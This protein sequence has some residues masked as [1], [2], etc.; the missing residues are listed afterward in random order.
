MVHRAERLGTG[1]IVAVKRAN[2]AVPLSADTLRREIALCATLFHP[3]IPALQDSGDAADGQPFAVFAH[4]PGMTLREHL[5]LRGPMEGAAAAA[6]MDQLL[7]ALAYLHDRGIVHHDI[8]PGN[9]MLTPSGQAQLIDFGSA[10]PAPH[11]LCSPAYSSP[12]QLRGDPPAP[13]FDLYACGLVLL[14]C[15]SG[16]PALPGHNLRQLIHFKRSGQDIPMP[17]LERH[18]LGALLRQ[19]LCKDPDRRLDDAR[20]L[21][22]RLRLLDLGGLDS[23]ARPRTTDIAPGPQDLATTQPPPS[24][25]VMR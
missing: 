5:L 13:G 14:E 1:D 23:L 19:V 24:S 17:G 25:P 15:L 2:P 16:V 18:P 6:L 22:R 11:R 20:L 21:R 9:I 12:E 4:V 10:S 3:H 7:D 8:K